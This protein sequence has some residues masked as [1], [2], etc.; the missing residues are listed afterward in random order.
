M[1]DLV[2]ERLARIRDG[3]ARLAAADAQRTVFG[4]STHDYHLAPPWPEARV[5]ELEDAYGV[6]LP[7]EYRRF[8]TTLGA[9]GAGPYYGLV[10]PRPLEL[11]AFPRVVT[12]ITTKAGD[13]VESGTPKRP[14]FGATSS[15]ARPFALDGVFEPSFVYD[16]PAL[17]SGATPYD[18]CLE[19]AQVGCGYFELLVVRGPGAGGV[20]SD[21]M[22][23]RDGARIAPTC[24][25][26]GAWYE[27]WLVQELG[28][29]GA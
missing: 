19:L 7:D 18:G 20:W 13:V 9:S 16:L 12:R 17:P 1:T 8:I 3:L 10:E 5:R 29:L 11:E 24:D 26:F 27:A 2:E 28:A 4:A 14:A 6:R 25:G 22:A 21:T 23:A 15:P